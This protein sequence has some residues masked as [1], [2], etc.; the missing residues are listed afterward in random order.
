LYRQAG[1]AYKEMFTRIVVF[2]VVLGSF[3]LVLG[4]PPSHPAPQTVPGAARAADDPPALESSDLAT[5][6]TRVEPLPAVIALRE[7][8]Q[9]D[10]EPIV[11]AAPRA[12]RSWISAPAVGL[13]VPV[14]CCYSDLSGRVIPA[15]GVATIDTR[16]GANNLYLLGHN[17]GVFTPL[18]GL[19]PGALVRYW[20]NAGQGHDFI[21]RSKI[22]VDRNDVSPLVASYASLTLTLQTCLTNTTSTVWVF[23]ATAR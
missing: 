8:P 12:R 23:R 15:H 2:L 5:I 3:P 21:I 16:A 9:P 11:V 19:G 7:E 14:I 18:L 1:A 17:P 13:E 20:D 10:P 4:T 6:A 22:S